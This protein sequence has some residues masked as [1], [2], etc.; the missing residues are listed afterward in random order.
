[1]D[2]TGHLLNTRSGVRGA[3]IWTMDARPTSIG[4]TTAMCVQCP[5][6]KLDLNLIGLYSLLVAINGACFVN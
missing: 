1:M 6:F 5:L 4:T 3:S 2:I